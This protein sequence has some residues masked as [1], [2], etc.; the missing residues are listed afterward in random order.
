M[1]KNDATYFADLEKNFYRTHGAGSNP[2][3]LKKGDLIKAKRS[4]LINFPV[5]IGQDTG[6][7]VTKGT[8]LVVTE[9]SNRGDTFARV[10]DGN[11]YRWKYE[12]GQHMR[13]GI[14]GVSIAAGP[15]GSFALH[16]KGGFEMGKA[17]YALGYVNPKYWEVCDE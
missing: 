9:G 3:K 15:S 10:V 1:D 12:W 11:A 13:K 14:I 7:Y 4:L 6:G 16:H 17:P 5:G 8:V 2:I